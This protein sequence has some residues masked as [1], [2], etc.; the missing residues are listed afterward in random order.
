MGGFILRSVLRCAGSLR[1]CREHQVWDSIAV[2]IQ[3]GNRFLVAR[4][5]LVPPL[6]EPATSIK[7]FGNPAGPL[8]GAIKR[9]TVINR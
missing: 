3:A 9:L 1:R 5:T 8:R 4:S 2:D 6:K 7:E